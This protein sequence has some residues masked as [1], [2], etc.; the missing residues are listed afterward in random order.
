LIKIE[1]ERRLGVPPPSRLPRILYN[2]CR[3]VSFSV[4]YADLGAYFQAQIQLNT[5]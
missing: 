3:H 4:R 1:K 5:Y 2:I